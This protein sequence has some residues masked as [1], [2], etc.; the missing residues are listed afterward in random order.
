MLID[1]S[2]PRRDML[3]IEIT[4]KSPRKKSKNRRQIDISNL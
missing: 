1:Q 2:N 3:S 4:I